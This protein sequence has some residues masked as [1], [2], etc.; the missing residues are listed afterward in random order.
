MRTFILVVFFSS[1]ALS[2][3]L[4]DDDVA[5]EISCGDFD[6]TGLTE[7]RPVIRV[8]P[9]FGDKLRGDPVESC[10]VVIYGLREK[11]G[12]DGKALLVHS[13][14]SVAW[15][16]EVPRKAR[17]AAERALKKWLFVS[18]THKASEDSV[19]FSVFTF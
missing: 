14:K 8:E 2:S 3:P 6:S 5:K 7:G 19:Y 12:T 1:L 15:S 4:A 17:R 13:V 9:A 11:A 16:Q 10:V 18:K